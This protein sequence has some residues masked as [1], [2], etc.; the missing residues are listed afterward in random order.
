ME[1]HVSR[2]DNQ[3]LPR[4]DTAKDVESDNGCSAMGEI[5]VRGDQNAGVPTKSKLQ[6][7]LKVLDHLRTKGLVPEDSSIPDIIAEAE[8]LLSVHGSTR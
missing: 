1:H 7:T 5:Q 8:T 2:I 4:A 6:S 3:M